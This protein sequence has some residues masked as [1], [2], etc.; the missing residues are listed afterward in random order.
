MDTTDRGWY[1]DPSDARRHR[2]GD[3]E[4]WLSECQQLRLQGHGGRCPDDDV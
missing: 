4:Q 3:G 1:R 2:Y